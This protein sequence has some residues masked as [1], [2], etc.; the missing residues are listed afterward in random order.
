MEM[1]RRKFIHKLLGAGS[2]ILAGA[3]LLAKKIVP[4]R[5]VRALRY[6]K[7]PGRFRAP[8]DIFNQSKWNG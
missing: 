2:L 1:T 5:F 6:H 4:G 7:Y 3:G 8:D